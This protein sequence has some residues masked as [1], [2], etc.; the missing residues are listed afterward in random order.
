MAKEEDKS[1]EKKKKTL[2]FEIEVALIPMKKGG[3]D[4][5]GVRCRFDAPFLLLLFW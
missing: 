2:K 3:N 1:E 5:V 4:S